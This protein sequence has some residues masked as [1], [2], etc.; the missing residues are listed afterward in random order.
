MTVM[1]FQ[2]DGSDQTL[3]EGIRTISGAIQGMLKP[4]RAIPL[5]VGAPVPPGE[6][7]EPAPHEATPPV[8]EDIVSTPAIGSQPRR[9]TQPRPPQVLPD[10]KVSVDELKQYCEAKQVGNKDSKRYLVIAAFLKEKMGVEA[11]TADHIYTCYRLLGW[12]TP[13]DAGA[14]LRALKSKGNFQKGDDPG[15]YILNHVGENAVR[16]MSKATDAP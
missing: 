4:T 15:A 8:G 5:H 6:E 16:D 13:A 14:P 2:L 12:N 11:V 1:V 7:V 3:Q 10:L 9:T